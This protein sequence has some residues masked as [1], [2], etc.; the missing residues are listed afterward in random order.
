[1]LTNDMEESNWLHLA[2]HG[3]QKSIEPIE[4]AVLLHNGDL[5]LEKITN[6][7]LPKAKFAILSACQITSWRG[8]RTHYGTEYYEIYIIAWLQQSGPFR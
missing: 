3:I 6:I 8:S 5:K 4:S 1:M 2:C 7:R